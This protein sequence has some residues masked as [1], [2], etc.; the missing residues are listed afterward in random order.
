MVVETFEILNEKEKRLVGTIETAHPRKRQPAVILLNGFIDHMETRPK[1]QIAKELL[2]QGYVVVRFDYTHGFGKGDGTPAR[3]T[4]TNQV[5]DTQRVIE[6]VL[7]RGYVDP[8]RLVLFGYCFGG[9]AAI[10]LGAFDKRVKAVV[11]LSSPYEFFDTSVT[12]MTDH[13]MS[14][15]RLKRYFHLTTPF[16]EQEERIDYLFLEDGERRDMPRAVRNLNQPLLVMHGDKDE[17]VPI[18][19]AHEIHERSPG[20]KQFEIIAGMEHAPTPKQVKAALDHTLAFLKK[21]LK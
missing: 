10:M 13:D 3:F 15:V 20:K 4:I 14:R 6:H 19:H 1:K 8:D 18:E 17:R 16:S 9:M 7:R 2:A 11:T 21:H 5:E 12:R